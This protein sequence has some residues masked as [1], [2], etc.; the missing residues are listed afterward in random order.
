M[1]RE[2]CRTRWKIQWMEVDGDTNQSVNYKN[3]Q[4]NWHYRTDWIYHSVC[5]FASRSS[6]PHSIYPNQ[7]AMH[8]NMSIIAM[9]ATLEHTKS[10]QEEKN[11]A[12]VASKFHLVDTLRSPLL[13]RWCWSRRKNIA[14]GY[15]FAQN[16]FFY[17]IQSPCSTCPIVV[18]IYLF[19]QE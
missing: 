6:S 15:D 10:M 16:Y 12:I 4:S 19:I 13:H 1:T 11:R 3:R 17:L 2:N 8:F 18:A 9:R 7:C 14:N 5:A